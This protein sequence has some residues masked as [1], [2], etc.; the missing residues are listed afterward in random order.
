MGIPFD[1]GVA[2]HK[3]TEFLESLE[4][5][6]TGKKYDAEKSARLY[7]YLIFEEI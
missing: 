6:P 3:I 1:F 7:T 4:I 5:N 2:N